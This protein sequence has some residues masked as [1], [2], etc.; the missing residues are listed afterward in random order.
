MNPPDVIWEMYA[1]VRDEGTPKE[2]LTFFGPLGY[3]QR[4][5]LAVRVVKVLLT[6][7]DE[8]VAGDYWAWLDY[9]AWQPC[10]IGATEQEMTTAFLAGEYDQPL[11]REVQEVGQG[12]ILRLQVT[13]LPEEVYLRSSTRGT[14]R[15]TSAM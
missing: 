12:Q 10:H 9:G 11:P 5:T 6:P 3:A 2:K 7:T 8:P 1:S 4:D 15:I 14:W 13:V